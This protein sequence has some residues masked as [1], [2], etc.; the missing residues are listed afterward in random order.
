MKGLPTIRSFGQRALLLEWPPEISLSTHQKVLQCV[1]SIETKLFNQV[2]EVV[3]TYHSL[4]IYLKEREDV[5]S[6]VEQLK[7]V[8]GQDSEA[9]RGR[10]QIITVPVCYDL[11]FALDLEEISSRICLSIPEIIELHTQPLYKVYFLGFLPGF[12]YLGGL[13]TRLHVP[14]RECPRPIIEKGNVGIGGKQTGLYPLDSPGGWNI[15]GKTPLRLFEAEKS[16][17]TQINTGDFVKFEP[18]TRTEFDL[19]RVEVE[20]DTFQWRK[21]ATG[22]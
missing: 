14:R 15:I 13:D 5:S 10:P 4:A 1:S 19:I 2:L 20:S 12:P 3:P 21:E 7:L 22:D 6:F 16:S 18:I 9:T 11:E 17:P 8:L